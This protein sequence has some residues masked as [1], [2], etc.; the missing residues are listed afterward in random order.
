[1]KACVEQIVKDPLQ[2]IRDIA[3][4]GHQEQKQLLIEW[5]STETNYIGNETIHGL[6]EAQA[7][8]TP[9]NIALVYEG[10]QLTY[11]ELNERSNQLAHYLRKLGVRC[12][13]VVAIAVD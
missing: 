6:F 13:T 5:N 3:F 8:N 11:Q 10:V 9:D 1:F 2:S 4:L 12:D 7:L